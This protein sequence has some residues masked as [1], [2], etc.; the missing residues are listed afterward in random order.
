L[1]VHDVEDEGDVEVRSLLL[2]SANSLHHGTHARAATTLRAGLLVDNRR[3]RI[4][5]RSINSRTRQGNYVVNSTSANL[6]V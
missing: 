2:P 5:G 1:A 3:S 4:A 6:N